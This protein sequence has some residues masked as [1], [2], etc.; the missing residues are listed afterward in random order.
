MAAKRKVCYKD[1]QKSKLTDDKHTLDVA[2]KEVYVVLAAQ[3]SKLQE[4]TVDLQSEYD[5]KNY[6]G[7]ARQMARERRKA[8]NIYCMKNNIRNN[9]SDTDNIKHIELIITLGSITIGLSV[10][11][12]MP[13][14][15]SKNGLK[16]GELIQ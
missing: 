1:W 7:I 14:V 16:Q 4:F 13:P 11:Y 10:I 6:F 12:R 5:R 9:M 2:K 8:L 15:K 3:E